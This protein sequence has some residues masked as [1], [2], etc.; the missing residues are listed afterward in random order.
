VVYSKLSVTKLRKSDECL[1]I[2][3]QKKFKGQQITVLQTM[4]KEKRD[5][6]LRQLTEIEGVS[7]RQIARVTGIS[8]NIIF[9]A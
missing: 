2:E 3:V 9:K 7:Y 5:E 6:I 4:E 8:P 1:H